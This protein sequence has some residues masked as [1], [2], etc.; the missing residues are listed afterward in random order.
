MKLKGGSMYKFREDKPPLRTSLPVFDLPVS[1]YERQKAE[2]LEARESGVEIV[3]PVVLARFGGN[4]WAADSNCLGVDPDLFFPDR[5]E[6]TKE[7]KDVC[8]RCIVQ[9]ECLE[10]ALE[11]GEKFG[12][13]G[14]KS[15]RERRRLRK[16]RRLARLALTAEEA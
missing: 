8:A 5:G 1:E 13:W 14:G 12:I 11:N 3:S 6:S 10:F 15:E 9:S 4:E 2:V 7:A 16:E